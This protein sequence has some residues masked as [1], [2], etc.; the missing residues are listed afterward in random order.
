[1]CECVPKNANSKQT[2]DI[3]RKKSEQNKKKKKAKKHSC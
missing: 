1:M 3:E 2:T